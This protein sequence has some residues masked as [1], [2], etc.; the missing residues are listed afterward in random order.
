M[1]GLS[2]GQSLQELPGLVAEGMEKE[3]GGWHGL[4]V[5]WSGICGP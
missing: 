2:S 5:G 3:F 4:T 1:S